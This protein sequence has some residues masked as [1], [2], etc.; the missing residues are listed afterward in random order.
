MTHDAPFV[1][2]LKPHPDIRQVIAGHV[3]LTSTAVYHGIPFTTLAGGHY[4]VSFDVDAPDQ[5]FR[6][7]TG[8][9]QIAVVIGLPHATTVLFEDF[10]DGN[11]VI[12]E[13][14]D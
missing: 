1:A 5:P 9:G 13:L 11:M 3:H 2:A 7:L 14:A 12:A 4:S 8:P 10:I 6:A